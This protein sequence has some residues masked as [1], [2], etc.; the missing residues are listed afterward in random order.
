VG[1]TARRKVLITHP[2]HPLNGRK[3]ELISRRQYW[4]EDRIVYLDRAGR[5]R[6]IA[7]A[8]TDLEPTDEFRLVAAGRA[9][10]RTVDLLELCRTL[11]RLNE[12]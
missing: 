10:F 11:D 3:I 1:T 9:A 4:G 7:S 12:R 8:W 2:F 6:W 5:L